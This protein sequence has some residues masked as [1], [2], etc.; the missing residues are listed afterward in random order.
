MLALLAA[1]QVVR[2]AV[3]ARYAE[4]NPQFAARIWP[5]HPSA[6][7][8]L[9]L[10]DI[11]S[12][13]HRRQPV[14]P[15]LVQRIM[16]AAKKAPLAPEPFLVRGVQAQL[17]GDER[18][19]EQAFLAARLRDGRSVPA[20]YFLAEHYFRVGNA[21]A[22]LR[23]I[24]ILARMVP[25]GVSSLAP[26]VATYAKDPRTRPKLKALFRSDPQLED[27][28]LQTLAGDPRNADLILSMADLGRYTDQAPPWSVPLLAGLVRD[29]QYGKA[30]DVWAKVSH[31][32]PVPRAFIF[33]PAFADDKTPPPF[34]WELTSSTIGLAE[35][36]PRGRL[37]IIFYGQEDGAMASQLL[38]LP[39]GRYR[40]AMNLSGD[41]AHSKSLVWSVRC[42]N[43]N[44][45][46]A[47][48]ALDP[49]AAARGW[50]LVV[51]ANCPAQKFELL[52]VAPDLPQQV[53]VTV[54]GL[55]LTREPGDG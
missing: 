19:A 32:R 20:R 7:L 30:Y 48:V 40:L 31:V 39:P 55:R 14:G 24:A 46:V 15:A 29:G 36:Q 50:Y 1:V 5:S 8:W 38:L 54:S 43:S 25:T 4:T 17:A 11:G 2:T 23:E 51:P 49:A 28:A 6:E 16:D 22:G 33:D 26:Y 42:A 47:R 37:H 12:A 27:A 44:A 10:T 9:G 41:V 3:V 45:Q 53:D 34:N 13:M 52:G 21:A 18:V 35:R